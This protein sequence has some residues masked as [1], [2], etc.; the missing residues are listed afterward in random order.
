MPVTPAYHPAR[1]YLDNRVRVDRHIPVLRVFLP[2]QLDGF[3]PL[4]TLNQ[5]FGSA[6]EQ[7]VPQALPVLFIVVYDQ[8]YLWVGLD[9]ADSSQSGKGRAFGLLVQH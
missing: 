1:G 5:H 2:Q 3:Y 4:I 6:G 7:N 9:V 8:G